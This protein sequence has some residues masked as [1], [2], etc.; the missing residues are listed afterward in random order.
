MDVE[1]PALPELAEQSG[2]PPLKSLRRVHWGRASR[3]EFLDTEI[4][5]LDAVG[6]GN[7]IAGPAIVEHA[8]TTFAIPP[9]RT[10]TLDSHQI[11]HLTSTEEM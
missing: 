1:K 8:A 7:S 6:S 10:A 4:F 11:F 2:T 9:G 5:E 3:D